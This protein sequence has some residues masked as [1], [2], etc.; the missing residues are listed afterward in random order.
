MQTALDETIAIL[1]LSHLQDR[2]AYRAATML[3]SHNFHKIVGVHPSGLP[4]LG[5]P[6]HKQLDEIETPIHTLTM[7]ISAEKSRPLI[8]SILRINPTR[9]IF[10]PGSES[11]ELEAAAADQG[12]Q[13]QRACTLVLLS[14][15][16]F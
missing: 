10:N 12:I 4:V 13:T 16:Q 3:Q 11:T 15:S 1:G 8:P 5:I 7:Y 9:I 2:Y 6:V 14:T